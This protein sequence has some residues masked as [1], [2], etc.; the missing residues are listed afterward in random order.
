MAH[1]ILASLLSR[2]MAQDYILVL[3]VKPEKII[4][5]GEVGHETEGRESPL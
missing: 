2:Y 5:G 3:Y 1:L 4:L